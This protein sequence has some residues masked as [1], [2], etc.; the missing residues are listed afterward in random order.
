[1]SAN[2]FSECFA[3]VLKNEGG[4]VDNPADPGGATNLGCT[5]TAGDVIIAWSNIG[6]Q[7]P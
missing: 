5:N 6:D 4:Y 3:L 2:N 7:W 1:M